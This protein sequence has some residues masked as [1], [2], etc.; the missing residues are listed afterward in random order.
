MSS[1][2]KNI[3]KLRKERGMS[4]DD[5]AARVYVTRQ[6]ISNWEIGKSNPALSD[7]ERLAQALDCEVTEILYGVK[8]GSYKKFQPRYLLLAAVC[9][10]VLAACGILQATVYPRLA[11]QVY[12]NFQTTGSTHYILTILPISSLS[13]AV[14]L[15]AVL[16]WFADIRIKWKKRWIVLSAAVLLLLLSFSLLLAHSILC[17]YPN[18]KGAFT[19]IYISYRYLFLMVAPFLSGIAFFIGC[20]RKSKKER[21]EVSI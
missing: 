2:N 18:P 10:A 21:N 19:L 5:L 17:R 12:V 13:C 7:I 6:T 1:I 20:N 4:Q 8:D 16:S 9:A 14:L 15:L 3:K 11:E